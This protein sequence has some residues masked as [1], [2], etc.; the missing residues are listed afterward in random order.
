MEVTG[1]SRSRVRALAR[2]WTVS[3]VAAILLA[4][5][6]SATA[7]LRPYEP[8]EWQL[9]DGS[10][11][12]VG[13]IGVEGFDDQRAS[14]A[15]ETGWL[16]EIGAFSAFIRTGRVAL[17][18]EGTLLRLFDREA[19]FA[20]V[21]GG[22]E[23]DE[24][25][26]RH[27]A[28]DY[29]ISTIVRLT[30]ADSRALAILRFGTRLP[31]TDNGVGLERDQIDFFAVVGGRLDRGRVRVAA[32]TGLG[33]HGTRNPGFE[34][35]DVLIYLVSVGIPNG[36]LSPSLILAGHADGLPDRNIRGNEE[37]AEVRLRLRTAGRVW[38]QVEAIAGLM[39][40]SARRGVSLLVG[41]TR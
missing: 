35:S 11:S 39:E 15:G 5:P 30:P 27:D 10:H 36:R 4:R 20:P 18:A 41:T 7:Q 17:G 28:G 25:G 16:A 23:A 19:V 13:S 8:A 26:R 32:E 2:L 21:H 3:V 38:M 9:F 34:Q 29:R 14:L 31:T 37:L 40:F 22:A 6:A 33:I 1:P 12:F 24:D